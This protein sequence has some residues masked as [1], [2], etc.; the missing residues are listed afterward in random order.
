MTLCSLQ[1]GALARSSSSQLRQAQ[2]VHRRPIV[3]PVG[4][5]RAAGWRAGASSGGRSGGGMSGGGGGD[6]LDGRLAGALLKDPVSFLGGVFAGFLALNLQQGK[7]EGRRRPPLTRSQPCCRCLP[8]G[9]PRH[10]L[11]RRPARS[12]APLPA[13]RA[14]AVVDRPDLC[15]SRAQVSSHRREAGGG[16]AGTQRL[17]F[18]MSVAASV[19][20]RTEMHAAQE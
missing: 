15:R 2:G 5:R 8:R 10:S 19:G 4:S 16:A 12:T 3:A 7:R 18:P 14:A 1:R 20:G 9:L 11:T 17:R 13:C 6:L